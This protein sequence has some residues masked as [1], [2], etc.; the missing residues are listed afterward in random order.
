MQYK[1]R[2]AVNLLFFL[3]LVPQCDSRMDAAVNAVLSRRSG[4]RDECWTG[5]GHVAGIAPD[6]SAAAQKKKLSNSR[7]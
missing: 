3:F 7:Q 5:A 4:K 1:R 2:Y 6:R